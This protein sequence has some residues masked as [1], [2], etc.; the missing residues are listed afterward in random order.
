MEVKSLSDRIIAGLFAAFLAIWPALGFISGISR[1]VEQ[2]LLAIIKYGTIQVSFLIVS[3]FLLCASMYYFFGG[4]SRFG[5][6]IKQ[7]AVSFGLISFLIAYALHTYTRY[8]MGNGYVM[9]MIIMAI[10]LCSI[11][12]SKCASIKSR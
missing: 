3:I 1:Q 2:D 12:V 10:A 8:L 11:I 9:P 5:R 4:Q 6:H 7:Y